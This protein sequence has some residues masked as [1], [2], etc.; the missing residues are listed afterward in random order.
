MACS[1]T[2]GGAGK[3]LP[4]TIPVHVEPRGQRKASKGCSKCLNFHKNIVSIVVRNA[5]GKEVLGKGF[6]T[7]GALKSIP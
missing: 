2:K 5:L 7:V 1:R 4:Q 3:P 6:N